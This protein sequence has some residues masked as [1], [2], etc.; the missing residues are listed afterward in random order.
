MNGGV[1]APPAMNRFPFSTRTA[2]RCVGEAVNG[3]DVI[4]KARL[5]HPDLIVP[6]ICM[7]VMDG[8]EA[9]R[10]LTR[11]MPDIPL[12]MFTSHGSKVMGGPTRHQ[13]AG[14]AVT[15]TSPERVV[16]VSIEPAPRQSSRFRTD[17]CAILLTLSQGTIE[18][19]RPPNHVPRH[20]SNKSSEGR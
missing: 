16:A 8:L 15:A 11:L 5:F 19:R 10:Q 12:M 3:L 1:L 9:S 7:P 20:S 6:D 2:L 17:V 4:E 13:C 18:G 14:I